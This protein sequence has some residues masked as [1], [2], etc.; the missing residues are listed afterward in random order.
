MVSSSTGE[1]ATLYGKPSRERI[2][3]RLGEAEASTKGIVIK[4]CAPER[5]RTRYGLSAETFRVAAQIVENKL[6]KYDR[7]YSG[8]VPGSMGRTRHK[9]FWQR[10]AVAM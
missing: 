2:C 4:G 1:T 10:D 6:G 3:R 7:V 8:R 5:R 9:R